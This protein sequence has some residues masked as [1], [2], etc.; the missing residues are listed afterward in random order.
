MALQSLFYT[1]TTMRAKTLEMSTPVPQ[2]KKNATKRQ[3]FFESPVPS[4]PVGFPRC[5]TL[6]IRIISIRHY[7]KQS[8]SNVLFGL[9]RCF[10][11]VK[12]VLD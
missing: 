11:A 2:R 6:I 1:L 10:L 9:A 8:V 7:R 4:R 5:P 3:I 12:Y